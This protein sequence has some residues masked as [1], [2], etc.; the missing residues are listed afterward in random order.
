VAAR[1]REAKVPAAASARPR[2]L[3]PAARGAYDA[4]IVAA[5]AFELF[6]RDGYDATSLD[7]VAAALGI[8]KAAIYY[9]HAGKEAILGFGLDAAMSAFEAILDEVPARAGAGSP[10]ERFEYVLRR[11]LDVGLRHHNEFAVLLR[12]RGNTELERAM[13]DRRRA[14]DHAAAGMLKAAVDA[15]E[16]TV[17]TDPALITRLV[18][19]LITSTVEWYRPDG[20]RDVGELVELTVRF[21]MRALPRP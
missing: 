17:D 18:M 16:L 7:Q 2:A 6:K 4:G 1:G 19:G 8:S 3:H 15:G 11:G 14:F 5:A 20:R 13:L 9:H 21:A 10:L 12:L